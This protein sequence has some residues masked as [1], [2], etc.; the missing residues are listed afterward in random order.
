VKHCNVVLSATEMLM[1]ASAGVCRQVHN[2]RSDKPTTY[3]SGHLHDW[4]YHCEGALGECALAKFLNVYWP[5]KGD[6]RD[7]DVGEMDVRTRSE[8]WYDMVLHDEDPDDRIYW[9]LTGING[10]YKVH[11]W[12]WAGDGKKDEYWS[13]PAKQGRHAYFVPQS[14]LFSPT[15]KRF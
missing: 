10:K 6:M 5:G 2:A 12:M 1:A 4:Q 15:L 11:G 3:G 9:L 14:K 13:D 7:A 8:H